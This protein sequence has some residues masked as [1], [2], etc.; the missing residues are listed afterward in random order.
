MS[1]PDVKQPMNF[2]E[3]ADYLLRPVCVSYMVD[4]VSTNKADNFS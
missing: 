2:L 4:E 3:V 1:C